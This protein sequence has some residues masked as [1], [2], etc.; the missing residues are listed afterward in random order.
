MPYTKGEKRICAVIEYYLV[1]HLII[2]ANVETLLGKTAVDNKTTVAVLEDQNA[3]VET[4]IT[5]A[6]AATTLTLLT[7]LKTTT[8]S[9]HASHNGS[10]MCIAP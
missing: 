1:L 6:G 2:H 9:S 4:T 8:T 5:G 7:N 10:T 3:V